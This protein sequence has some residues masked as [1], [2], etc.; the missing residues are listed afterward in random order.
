M[1]LVNQ[2]VFDLC[3]HVWTVTTNPELVCRIQRSES[4]CEVRIECDVGQRIEISTQTVL[5]LKE[6]LKLTCP[7]AD[8]KDKSA[9]LDGLGSIQCVRRLGDAAINRKE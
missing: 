3:L 6:E 2:L 7:A 4:S 5:A 1:E 8:R 9:R